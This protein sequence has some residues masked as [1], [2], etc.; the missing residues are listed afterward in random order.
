MSLY[1]SQHNS[2][3]YHRHVKLGELFQWWKLQPSALSSVQN[4]NK[5]TWLDGKGHFQTIAN[6]HHA[7]TYLDHGFVVGVCNLQMYIVVYFIQ[8]LKTC[9]RARFQ[10]GSKIFATHL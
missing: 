6:Y 4:L 7:A 5:L 9:R 2:K 1:E 10:K 8:V 3:G